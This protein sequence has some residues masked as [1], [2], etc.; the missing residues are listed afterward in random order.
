MPTPEELHKLI[1]ALAKDLRG[2]ICSQYDVATIRCR[3]AIASVKRHALLFLPS[4]SLRRRTPS[5][6]TCSDCMTCLHQP[7]LL[8]PSS[9]RTSA[10]DSSPSISLLSLLVSG[11]MPFLCKKGY[12]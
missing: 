6:N 5:R 4:L 10:Q 3:N 12:Q 7:V 8:A 9:P 2:P 11:V 1:D